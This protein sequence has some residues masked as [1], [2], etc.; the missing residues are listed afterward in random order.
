M[1]WLQLTS[2]FSGIAKYR[3]TLKSLVLN[4]NAVDWS[5]GENR[6]NRGNPMAGTTDIVVQLVDSTGSFV[7][8]HGEFTCMVDVNSNWAE[9]RSHDSVEIFGN[10]GRCTPKCRKSETRREGHN[11][12]ARL[13]RGV[14]TFLSSQPKDQLAAQLPFVASATI[15]C[16]RDKTA[17][18]LRGHDHH[19]FSTDL[20][21][22][23]VERN[24]P[25]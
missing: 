24:L 21:G 8:R 5:T 25:A 1:S 14:S 22:R 17:N 2:E 6:R 7:K 20:P 9:N 11:D 23:P 15:Y 12:T 10:K 19:H 18:S 16:I 3:R 4:F 13:G